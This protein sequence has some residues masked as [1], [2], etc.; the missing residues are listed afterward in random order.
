MIGQQRLIDDEIPYT[1]P[2]NSAVLI[3]PTS[4]ISNNSSIS[5]PSSQ[6]AHLISP[7]MNNSQQNQL[8]NS[9]N[10]N[11]VAHSQ[12]AHQIGG[13][14]PLTPISAHHQALKNQLQQHFANNNMGKLCSSSIFSNNVYQSMGLILRVSPFRVGVKKLMKNQF[15]MII[16]ENMVKHIAS[17]VQS[18]AVLLSSSLLA[19]VCE[20]YRMNYE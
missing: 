3:S 9:Q 11:L 13:H 14:Q 17:F 20:N 1:S 4:M 2:S 19:L 7:P 8:N 6:S 15:P 16:L 10:G 12:S 18:A 5:V